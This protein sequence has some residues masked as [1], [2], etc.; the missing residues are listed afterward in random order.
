MIALR[1][2]RWKKLQRSIVI[3]FL[4]NTCSIISGT[5]ILIYNMYGKANI[6]GNNIVWM[7]RHYLM[8]SSN[9]QIL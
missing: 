9:S 6:I 8:P 4:Q 5:G 1:I 3:N 2:H 7:Q